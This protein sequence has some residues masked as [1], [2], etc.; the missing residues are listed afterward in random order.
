MPEEGEAVADFAAALSVASVAAGKTESLGSAA[1]RDAQPQ[2]AG[3][4]TPATADTLPA[5]GSN[6][7]RAAI[8]VAMGL[9]CGGFVFRR[10][11]RRVRA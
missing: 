2:I 10:R 1:P 4:V 11:A 5:T 9:L 7:P 6:D 8:V 3:G